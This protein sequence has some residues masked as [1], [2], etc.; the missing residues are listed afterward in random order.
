M[1]A[2]EQYSSQNTSRLGLWRVKTARFLESPFLHKIIIALIVIDAGC[3]LADL[4]YAFLSDTCTPAE[5]EDAPAWL[6]VLAHISLVIT[7]LFLVEI[8]LA[9][10]SFGF[11]YYNPISGVPHATLHIFDAF[12]I[13]TTFVLEVALKGREQELAALLIILRLWRLVKLVGGVAVGAGELDEENVRLLEET[14]LELEETKKQL[15]TVQRD[16]S[17]LRKRITALGGPLPGTTR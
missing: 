5:G 9:F 17:E 10:W 7:T 12:I 13:T 4:G 1:E 8:P 2:G 15:V 11:H 14:Q 16:N 3:V 6:E